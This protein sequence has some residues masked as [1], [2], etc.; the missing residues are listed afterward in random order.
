MFI[1]YL[2][3]VIIAVILFYFSDRKNIIDGRDLS[4]DKEDICVVSFL[5]LCPYLN[6]CTIFM[7][8]YCLIS[9]EEL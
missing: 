9:G 2:I 1:G 7:L 4:R 6:I 8:I 5:I 3:T